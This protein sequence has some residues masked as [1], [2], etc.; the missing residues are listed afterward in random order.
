MKL[1]KVF[2]EILNL[3]FEFFYENKNN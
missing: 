3:I 1:V 2:T